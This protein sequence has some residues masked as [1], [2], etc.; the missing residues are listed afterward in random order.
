RAGCPRMAEGLRRKAIC[1]AGFDP[2]ASG[3]VGPSTG[4]TT[5]FA[6][7]QNVCE[8]TAC[9]TVARRHRRPLSLLHLLSLLFFAAVREMT[10]KLPIKVR[11]PWPRM[12]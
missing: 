7:V 10:H 9:D 1:W 4:R 3:E 8:G 5:R 11:S 2:A 6:P 12:T